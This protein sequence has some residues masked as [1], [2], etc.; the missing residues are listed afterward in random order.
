MAK[1]VNVF[2]E[3]TPFLD[4]SSFDNLIVSKISFIRLA[5]FFLEKRRVKYFEL[6][7]KK[8]CKMP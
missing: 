5:F 1:E 2:S 4:K 7:K 3:C 6:Y 8:S